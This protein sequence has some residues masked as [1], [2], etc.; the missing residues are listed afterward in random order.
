[1][2]ATVRST[3]VGVG[4]RCQLGGLPVGDYPIQVSTDSGSACGELEPDARDRAILSVLLRQDRPAGT[5]VALSDSG[6]IVADF[7]AGAGVGFAGGV[8]G[9]VAG[10]VVGDRKSVG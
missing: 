4:R 2:S 9:G 10:G 7:R 8:P 1:C 6:R 5:I 3:R